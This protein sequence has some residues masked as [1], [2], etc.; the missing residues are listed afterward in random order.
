MHRTAARLTAAAVLLTFTAAAAPANPRAD[1]L[2]AEASRHIYNLDRDQ[3]IALYRQAIAADPGHSAAYRGLATALWL[4]ITLRRGTMTV[5]DY[6]GRVTESNAGPAA[7]P[8]SDVAAAFNAAVDKGIG[9]A[10]KR[11]ETN[12]GDVDAHYQL[13]AAV[14]LRA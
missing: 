8:P 4:S 10:R 1:A 13:G 7:P 14:G 5:D 12:R 11:L 2:R 9:L 3:A 6:L